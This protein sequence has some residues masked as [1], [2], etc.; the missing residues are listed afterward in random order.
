M[1][2]KV[3]LYIYNRATRYVKRTLVPCESVRVF[4]KKTDLYHNKPVLV[5]MVEYS[6]THPITGNISHLAM[7][8]TI[9]NNLPVVNDLNAS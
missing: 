7:P 6:Y 8:K 5:E 9:W 4:S 1:T 3:N 2:R